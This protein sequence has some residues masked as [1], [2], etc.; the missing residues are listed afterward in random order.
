MEQCVKVSNKV[1]AM[2]GMINR[3]IKYKVVVQLHKSLVRPHVD[4]CIQAWRPFKQKDINLLE[5]VQCKKS[6]YKG[7][8]GVSLNITYCIIYEH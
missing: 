3:A 1:D 8:E 7:S 6:A 5:S 4:Y 2:L